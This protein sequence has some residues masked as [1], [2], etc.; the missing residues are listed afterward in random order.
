MVCGLNLV[1][2]GKFIGYMPI[3]HK[4]VYHTWGGTNLHI[5]S[6]PIQIMG[7]SQ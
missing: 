3:K 2:Y 4:G 5:T 1:N 7:L 6:G